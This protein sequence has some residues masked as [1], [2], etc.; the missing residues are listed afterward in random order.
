MVKVDCA[1]A[2]KVSDERI[3]RLR[4]KMSNRLIFKERA[5]GPGTRAL[6]RSR[7]NRSERFPRCANACV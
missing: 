5:R 7:T 3:G 2:L 1:S 6:G 4:R